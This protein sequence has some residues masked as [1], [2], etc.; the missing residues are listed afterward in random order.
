MIAHP[1]LV[2][3]EDDLKQKYIKIK[4]Q[5]TIT[6]SPIIKSLAGK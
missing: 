3:R 2:Y 4:Q 1:Y 5:N 6:V